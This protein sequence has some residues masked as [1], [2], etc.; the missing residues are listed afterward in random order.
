MSLKHKFAGTIYSLDAGQIEIQPD[1]GG[2]I[3]DILFNDTDLTENEINN[4]SNFNRV[5][6]KYEQWDFKNN[7]PVPKGKGYN[8]RGMKNITIKPV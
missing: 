8:Y 7:G 4:L 3:Q 1:G 2:R 6:V 5:E